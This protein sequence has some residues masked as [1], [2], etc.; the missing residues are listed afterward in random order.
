M[1]T[2]EN[3]VTRRSLEGC[4]KQL[5]RQQSVSSEGGGGDRISRTIISLS[6]EIILSINRLIQRITVSGWATQEKINLMM[7]HLKP[8]FK[9]VFKS[10][11]G[12]DIVSQTSKVGAIRM[13]HSI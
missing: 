5:E 8:Q 3:T 4:M 10:N 9:T 1:E 7:K 11:G 6:V 2:D 12:A 13:G